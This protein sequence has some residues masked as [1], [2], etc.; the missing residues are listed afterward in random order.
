MATDLQLVGDTLSALQP[1]AQQEKCAP[2]ECLQA[3]LVELRMALEEL[4]EGA[5][6][7]RL[8]SAVT[9]AMQIQSPH[10]CLGC[11]PC[12]PGDTLVAYYREQQAQEIPSPCACKDG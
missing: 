7:E 5:E 11:K 6:R 10:G 4:P 1:F 3:A 12:P 9:Q 2:C 8:L